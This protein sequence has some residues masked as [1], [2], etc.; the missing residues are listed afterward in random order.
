MTRLFALSLSAVATIT[1]ANTVLAC[2]GGGY[3]SGN[4]GSY[5]YGSG[6][7]SGY[8]YQGGYA[9]SYDYGYG[10]GYDSGYDDSSG[11]GYGNSYSS[12]DSDSYYGRDTVY[13]GY[14]YSQQRQPQSPPRAPR[15]S[16][17]G[18]DAPAT[19]SRV[20]DRRPAV[21]TRPQQSFRPRQN[22]TPP[23]TSRPPQSFRPQQNSVRP[24]ITRPPGQSG[25]SRSPSILS[26]DRLP[27][28]S[29]LRSSQ[30]RP[31]LLEAFD[32]NG[33]FLGF[34]RP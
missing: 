8:G 22:F 6:Y 11:G 21:N 10:G 9:R 24:P 33:R 14:P 28:G 20:P 29:R 5:G 12:Y 15:E 23:Q 3:S 27:D 16:F 2:G 25:T 4:C 17:S 18:F 19:A 34:T 13:T 30:R 26:A 7:G 1:A 32:R 31:G